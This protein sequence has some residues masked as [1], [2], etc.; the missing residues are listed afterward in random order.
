MITPLVMPFVLA[1]T[2]PAGQA[3]RPAEAGAG[4]DERA[5]RAQAKAFSAAYVA[6]NLDGILEIYCRDAVIAPPR[7]DF[8][9]GDALVSYW[10]PRSGVV[11]AEHLLEPVAIEIHGELAIDHGYYSGAMGPEGEPVAFRGKYLVVWQR[12]EDGSWCMSQDMWNAQG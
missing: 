12:Q 6:G 7:R 5:I 11:V 3:G 10:R 8:L 4:Q 9:S 1:L 2:A